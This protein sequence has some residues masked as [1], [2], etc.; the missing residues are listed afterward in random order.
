[1]GSRGSGSGKSAGGANLIDDHKLHKIDFNGGYVK[2]ILY[3]EAQGNNIYID[4]LHT[5]LDKRG[6]GIG[7]NMLNS[8]KKTADRTNS[9]IELLASPFDK[10]MSTDSLVK[11]YE[12][13]GFKHLGANRMKY[14][15]K[16]KRK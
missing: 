9:T 2:Y 11:W 10:G 6:Q 16:S 1:M 12:K 15:P 3:P 13:R 8:I 4:E 7:T 14:T 5:D